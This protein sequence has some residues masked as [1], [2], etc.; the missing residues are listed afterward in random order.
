MLL[1]IPKGWFDLVLSIEAPDVT[2]ISL[3]TIKA[4]EACL[5][6]SHVIKL[7]T[8]IQPTH[9]LSDEDARSCQKRWITKTKSRHRYRGKAIKKAPL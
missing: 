7:T 3:K 8:G 5:S 2:Y 9:C 4:L 1:V 6:N